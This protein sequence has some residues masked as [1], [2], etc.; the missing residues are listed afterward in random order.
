VHEGALLAADEEL[1]AGDNPAQLSPLVSMLGIEKSAEIDVLVDENVDSYFQRSD[2]H[3][4]ALDLTA[5]R[6]GHHALARVIERWVRHLLNVEVAV[7]PL[8]EVQ[9]ANLTWYVG[10]DAEGTKIGDLLWNGEA[11]DEATS[12]RVAA[13]YRLTFRDPAALAPAVKGEPVYLILATSPE[14]VLRMKPQNLVT[15]MPIRQLEAVS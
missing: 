8:T 11:L 14:K 1:I 13:L 9:S 5:G 2:R 6:R 15:G 3:D 10:L 4:M 12:A 7:E